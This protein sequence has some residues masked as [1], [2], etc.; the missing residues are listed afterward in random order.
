MWKGGEKK[1]I[2][3]II[4]SLKDLSVGLIE[5]LLIEMRRRGIGIGVE[6]NGGR[7]RNEMLNDSEENGRI[8]MMKLEILI[9]E[10]DEIIEE[11]KEGKERKGKKI[12]RKRRGVLGDGRIEKIGG[13]IRNKKI[14]GEKIKGRRVRSGL[15]MD[16][17]ESYKDLNF[18][19][20]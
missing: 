13:E 14:E 11:E 5:E 12:W 10:G 19:K 20:L 1:G 9:G 3:K 16:E 4:D 18:W 7:E 6:G 15:G 8:K 17:N 2:D